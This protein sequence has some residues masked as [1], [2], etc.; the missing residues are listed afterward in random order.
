MTAKSPGQRLGKPLQL[1]DAQQHAHHRRAEDEQTH[2]NFVTLI[3]AFEQHD[4]FPVRYFIPASHYRSVVDYSEN[5]LKTAG[6]SL[7]G[8]H[9]TVRPCVKENRRSKTFPGKPFSG[10]PPAFQNGDGR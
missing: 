2:R 10:N 1:L 8:L 4:P 7:K 9:Q 3:D 6:A 5:A